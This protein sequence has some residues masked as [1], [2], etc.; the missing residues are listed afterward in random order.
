MLPQHLQTNEVKDRLGA[1]VEFLRTSNP[2][3][4]VVFEKSGQQPAYPV[5]LT[6]SHSFVGAGLKRVRR[7]LLR[8]DKVVVSNVD[9]SLPVIITSYKVDIVPIGAI[10]G[11]NDVTDVQ[12]HMMSLIASKG[13]STTILYDG[14][15]YGAEFALNGTL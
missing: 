10:T 13:A 5:R 8:I 9:A 11:L 1:E 7:S 4:G 3:A 6:F 2:V 15:G 12:A 14:T